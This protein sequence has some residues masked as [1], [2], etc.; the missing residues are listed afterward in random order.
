MKHITIFTDG[1]C[2]GNPGPG[3]YAALLRHGDHCREV[4]GG[5]ARTTN[6]RMELCAAIEGLASLREPCRVTLHSDS[7]FL[8]YAMSMR[9]IRNWK[10]RGWR[11][12]A[13]Q[14]VKN[15][16][17]WQRLEALAVHHTVEWNWVRG[18]D[19]NEDNE[20]CDALAVSAAAAEDLPPDTGYLEELAHDQAQLDLF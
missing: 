9:W 18:H 16:D 17:L 8:V 7:S 11:T 4:S 1:A 15:Q 13:R 10:A 20:R 19:G 2:S 3:G 6:N 14:R 12:A 5:F